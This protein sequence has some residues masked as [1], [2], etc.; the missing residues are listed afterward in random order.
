MIILQKSQAYRTT[1]CL[2]SRIMLNIDQEEKLQINQPSHANFLPVDWMV[3][4]DF[5]VADHQGPSKKP[6][7][8]GRTHVQR[9]GSIC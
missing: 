5:G 2:F 3:K 4:Y 9:G 8:Q 1:Q 6:L 7:G